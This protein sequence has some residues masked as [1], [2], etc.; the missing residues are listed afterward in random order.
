MLVGE[1][2]PINYLDGLCIAALVSCLVIETI[3]DEQQWTYQHIKHAAP[4]HPTRSATSKPSLISY[5]QPE[6]LKRG[7]LV[8]GLWKY[9][10]HPNFACE[11]TIWYLFYVFGGIATVYN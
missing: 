5:C 8:G 2:T 7:F 3:A 10:R 1:D 11:Q 4:P 9:S 6:D